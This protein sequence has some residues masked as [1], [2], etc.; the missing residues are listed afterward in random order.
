MTHGHEVMGQIAFPEERP[1]SPRIMRAL[2]RGPVTRPSRQPRSARKPEQTVTRPLAEWHEMTPGEQLAIWGRLRAWVTWLHDRYELSAEERLPRCWA[3]HPGL[4]EELYALMVWREEVYTSDQPSGQAARYWHAELRQVL[5][6][7]TMYAA[8]C[9]TG[10]RGA[11]CLAATDPDLRRQWAESSPLAGVPAADRLAGH[12][13]RVGDGWVPAVAIAQA[14]DA[15]F[16]EPLR[17]LAA[18]YVACDGELWTP[19]ANGW[20]T[21]D[22][23]GDD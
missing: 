23:Q 7:A 1:P 14:I 5:H 22:E 6:A 21:A 12:A 13:R 9:R 8:G 10:H 4:V 3:S 19:A 18:D 17:G 20:T 2:R 11:P 15:G 16:A